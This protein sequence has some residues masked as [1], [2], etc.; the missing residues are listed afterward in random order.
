V[1]VFLSCFQVPGA[2]FTEGKLR[3]QLPFLREQIEF[4]QPDRDVLRVDKAT[5]EHTCTLEDVLFTTM[6]FK[7]LEFS[8]MGKWNWKYDMLRTCHH[9]SMR[10][11]N[12][13]KISV[14]KLEANLSLRRPCHLW[15]NNIK[16]T[17]FGGVDWIEMAQVRVQSRAVVE[18][19]WFF[20]FHKS[21]RI[22]CATERIS[23]YQLR[24]YF[25]D[26]GIVTMEFA[27]DLGSA[28]GWGKPTVFSLWPAT[29]EYQL[30]RHLAEVQSCLVR[31]R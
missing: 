28:L 14:G 5:D 2:L 9:V 29:E 4:N 30:K 11:K 23:A 12:A 24:L 3:S 27:V 19:Y 13:H 20:E 10:C 1:F 25:K 6:A 15:A 22:Y 26:L 17:A 8:T 21:Q 31:G 18:R 16:E 7:Q